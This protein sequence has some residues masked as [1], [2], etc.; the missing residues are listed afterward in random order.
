[1]SSNIKLHS[2]INNILRMFHSQTIR[3]QE[4]STVNVCEQP[5]RST[6]RSENDWCSRN[7]P[8]SLK[9]ISDLFVCLIILIVLIVTIVH[10]VTGVA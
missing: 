2:Q 4:R 7:V 5:E 1:M 6:V 10:Y 9:Y 3:F 8:L